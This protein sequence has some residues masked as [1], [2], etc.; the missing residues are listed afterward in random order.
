[1]ITT[2]NCKKHKLCAHD[3]ITGCLQCAAEGGGVA[4][5]QT[6]NSDYAAAIRALGVFAKESTLEITIPM[7]RRFCEDRLH[8]EEPNVA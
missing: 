1:V 6:T 2:G 7:F 8:S 5:L 3:T 4:A